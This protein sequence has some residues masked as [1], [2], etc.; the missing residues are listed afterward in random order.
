M[1][2]KKQSS[3]SEKQLQ[4]IFL[5][6]V[7][8]KFLQENSAHVYGIPE[9]CTKPRI[10]N[11]KT[12]WENI[13]EIHPSV[14][15]DWVRDYSI[16]DG[17]YTG[18][19]NEPEFYLQM[20]T[21]NTTNP[22]DSPCQPNCFSE[23][24]VKP[25]MRKVI[26]RESTLADEKAKLMNAMDIHIKERLVQQLKADYSEYKLM[27]SCQ[28]IVPTL[29]N[30]AGIDMFMLE[31]DGTIVELDIKTTR[32]LIGCSGT[33]ISKPDA[34]RKLYEEQGKDRFSAKSRTYI[35]LPPDRLEFYSEE[36]IEKQLNE[37]YDIVFT[38]DRN[39]P[40]DGEYAVTDCRLIYMCRWKHLLNDCFAWL[41][42]T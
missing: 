29:K 1:Q 39:S 34:I 9:R 30:K 23:S 16:T 2:S 37:T 42:N 40:H 38:Y 33:D 17:K 41:A 7:A 26:N 11:G 25:S 24:C 8:E 6:P 15:K 20:I 28:K 21:D 13:A 35:Y 22:S 36:E 32:S 31:E 19:H 27:M 12:V 18:C 14:V 3:F 4:R 10:I 5:K